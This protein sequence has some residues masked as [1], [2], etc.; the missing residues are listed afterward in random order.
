MNEVER[1]KNLRKSILLNNTIFLPKDKADECTFLLEAYEEFIKEKR[2]EEYLAM[3]DK[4]FEEAESG[5]F[6]TKEV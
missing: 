2:N 5:G 4:S 3:L 6:I 1:I